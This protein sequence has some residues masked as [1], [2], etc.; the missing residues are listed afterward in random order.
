MAKSA[1]DERLDSWKEI[2]AFL[3]R[4]VRIDAVIGSIES[5]ILPSV[6]KFKE[7]GS[8]SEGEIEVLE[9]IGREPRALR[10]TSIEIKNAA[11]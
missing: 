3:K 6:R 4:G 2:A 8:T 5:R 11:E 9:K 1:S 10:V 7:L